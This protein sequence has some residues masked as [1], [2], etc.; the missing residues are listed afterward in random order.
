MSHPPTGT[1]GGL[2][3]GHTF[4]MAISPFPRELAASDVSPRALDRMRRPESLVAS[5]EK[6][7]CESPSAPPPRR[8]PAPRSILPYSGH[9]FRPIALAPDH[10]IT[11]VTRSS[12]SGKSMG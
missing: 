1:R 8:H 3:G 9:N 6:R 12:T 5:Q 11:S 7:T 4:G 10:L 2:T